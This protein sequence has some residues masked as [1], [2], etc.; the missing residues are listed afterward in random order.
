MKYLICALAAFALPVVMA[1]AGP[2]PHTDFEIG[3]DGTASHA[4]VIAGDPDI[5]SGAEPIELALQVGGPLD[6][7]YA[8]N[9]PGWESVEVDEPDEGLFTLLTPHQVSL[10]RVSATPGFAMA[11]LFFATILD[12]DGSSYAFGQDGDGDIHE[13]LFFTAPA[14]GEYTATLQLTDPSGT[15]AASEAYTLRFV[16]VPEPGS[17]AF[18]A[19]AVL[20][21]WRRRLTRHRS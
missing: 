11:D 12:T 21:G 9:E 8:A 16:A 1:S 3:Q 15:H 2:V 4:L 19:T 17:L 6:G 14:L 7:L 10:H 5:L 20:L 18:L 13:D